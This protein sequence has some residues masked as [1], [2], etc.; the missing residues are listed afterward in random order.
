MRALV[1]AAG[2]GSRLHHYTDDRPKPM[3]EIGGEP[4]HGYNLAM[5]AAARFD[6]IIVNLH[7]AAN[8]IRD[9][10][11]DG[12]RWG[13]RVAYSEE[14]ERGGT[15]G[16]LIPIAD[17]LAGGTFRHRLRGQPQRPRS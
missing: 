4:I 8:V 6:E 14:P 15:A 10:V 7:Y 9:Y 5:L 11:G 13:V 12:S 2:I 16:A 3:L 1:L 17:R